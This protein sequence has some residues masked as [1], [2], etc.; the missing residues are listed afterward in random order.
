MKNNKYKILVLSDVSKSEVTTLKASVSLAN[1]IGGEIDFLHVKRPAEIVEKENQLSAIRTIKEEYVVTE[2]KIQ[3]LIHPISKE[4]NI[5]INY[6]QRIGNVKNEIGKY[7]EE[8]RPDIIVLGKKKYKLLNIGGDEIIQFILSKH[9]GVILIASNI[10]PLEPKKELSL[11]L[12]N[13]IQ[14]T[15]NVDFS[16]DLMLHSKKPLKTFKI[17]NN[18][19]ALM[20]NLNSEVSKTIEY[21]FEDGSYNMDNLNNYALKSKINLF[22]IDREEKVTNNEAFRAVNIK[23]AIN[24]LD[25]SLLISGVKNYSLN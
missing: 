6:L 13:G 21:V 11:G 1:M 5:H 7:I 14:K 4:N 18:S 16:E 22:C 9:E 10:N 20:E 3:K 12:L 17:A 8:Y 23:D 25:V 19:N 2:K 24:K 15:L